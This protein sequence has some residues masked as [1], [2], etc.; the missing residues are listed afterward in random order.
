MAIVSLPEGNHL[1]SIIYASLTQLLYTVFVHHST[2]KGPWHEET[3]RGHKY[4][5]NHSHPN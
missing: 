4:E 1:C 5:T 3:P 2:S